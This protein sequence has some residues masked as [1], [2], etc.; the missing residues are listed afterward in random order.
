MAVDTYSNLIAAIETWSERDYSDSQLDEF[1]A[2]AESAFNRK[3]GANY[4]RK[5]EATITTD[6]NGE[7]TI[8]S[9]VIRIESLTR[10]LSG[11][12]PL[13]QVSWAALIALNPYE[14]ADEAYWFAIQGT[15]LRVAP[16]VEDDFLAVYWAKLTGLSSSN[17]TNWLLDLAPDAY[18]AMCR[19]LQAAFEEDEQ[20]AALYEAKA[21][22]ILDEVISQANVAEYGSADLVL[23]GCVP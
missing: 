6:S 17:A 13:A 1:I 18:L 3:L 9:G 14:E 7:G 4:R 16:I 10:D 23:P 2:L 19:S 20:R 21:Y 8:P 11:S 22:T 5:A 12:V 15:T